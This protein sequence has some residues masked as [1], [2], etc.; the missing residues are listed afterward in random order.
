M[1]NITISKKEYDNL[2]EKAFRF[3]YLQQVLKEDIFSSPPSK[4]SDLI[5]KEFKKT[6]K[7][8]GSFLKSLSK[9]LKRS[10]YFK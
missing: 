9:G 10:S 6:K 5:M 1:P 4:N 3:E 7:Y 8:N 2:I